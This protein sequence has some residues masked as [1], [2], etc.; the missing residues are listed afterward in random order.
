MVFT[1]PDTL[2][3][4]ASFFRDPDAALQGSWDL[5]YS[6]YSALLKSSLGSPE[7]I[8]ETIVAS[9]PLIFGGLSVAL[10]FKAGLFNIG[11]EGQLL[12]GAMAASYVGFKFTV[13]RRPSTSHSPFLRGSSA[14]CP[15]GVHPRDPEGEDRARTR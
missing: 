6:A 3:L 8:S 15:V 14:G 5:V 7:A 9:T 4:W 1:D 10:A 2:R 13:C 11:A 12:V